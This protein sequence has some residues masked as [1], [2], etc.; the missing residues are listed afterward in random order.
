MLEDLRADELVRQVVL[1]RAVVLQHLIVQRRR[2]CFAVAA[3]DRKQ[4]L[5][6]RLVAARL[7][8]LRLDQSLQLGVLGVVFDLQLFLVLRYFV[9]L[10]IL[11]GGLGVELCRVQ[12]DL[13]LLHLRLRQGGVVSQQL[14]ALFDVLPFLDV[15]R[16]DL[17]GL[18]DIDLL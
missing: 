5:L 15:D 16:T 1:L 9:Q 11:F 4:P 17:L 13:R 3:F 2:L 8:V 14:I 18:G 6:H 12:I 10:Q 7:L